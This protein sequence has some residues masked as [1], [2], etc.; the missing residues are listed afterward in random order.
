[1][2]GIVFSV[3]M[4]FGLFITALLGPMAIGLSLL[5]VGQKAVFGW[6][7]GFYSVGS[8]KIFYSL[9]IGL[10]A[11]MLIGGGIQDAIFAY[12]VGIV[13]PLLSFIMGAGGRSKK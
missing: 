13:A 12:M 11:D 5:P 1:M 8:I 4:D 2:M 3:A 10:M 9:M 7:I 6:L